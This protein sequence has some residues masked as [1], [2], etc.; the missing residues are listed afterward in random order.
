[1]PG[2]SPDTSQEPPSVLVWVCCC[3]QN[4]L[5]Q[6]HFPESLASSAKEARTC[7]Q[8]LCRA[9]P[10]LWWV[11]CDQMASTKLP[12]PPL[13]TQARGEMGAGEERS[14]FQQPLQDF[15]AL[16]APQVCQD[17]WRCPGTGSPRQ[18]SCTPPRHRKA[19]QE[20]LGIGSKIA[21]GEQKHVLVSAA[22]ETECAAQLGADQLH[23][24][25]EISRCWSAA[26]AH[27]LRAAH[28]APARLL[29]GTKR[30]S[31]LGSAGR[32]LRLGAKVVPAV[33]ERLPTP[34]P[35]R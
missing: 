8:Q 33:G 4:H 28:R 30:G 31:W 1:M 9:M 3:Q 6:G 11:P 21:I 26:G 25:T 24:R 15:L 32:V 7:P 5:V 20:S 10:P 23:Y 16:T 18:G 29:L 14:N 19:A 27:A 12:S 34:L 22:C 17:T 2:A 13:D 35:S